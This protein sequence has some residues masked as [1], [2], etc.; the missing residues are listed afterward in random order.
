MMPLTAA[1]AEKIEQNLEDMNEDDGYSDLLNADLDAT[2][3]SLNTLFSEFSRIMS[4]DRSGE[5]LAD[6]IH[7]D[8]AD[9]ESLRALLSRIQNDNKILVCKQVEILGISHVNWE[10][11]TFLISEKAS[12][13]ELF[14]LIGGV[15]ESLLMLCLGCEEENELI[16][17][18]RIAVQRPESNET[19]IYTIQPEDLNLGLT[20]DEIDIIRKHSRFASHYLSVGAMCGMPRNEKH[21]R[22]LRCKSQ[23]ITLLTS[24]GEC[25]FCRD[26]PYPEVIY[27]AVDGQMHYTPSLYFNADTIQ[28]ESGERLSKKACICC[29]RHVTELRNGLYCNLCATAMA[30]QGS[31]LR[32]GTENYKKYSSILPLHIRIAAVKKTKLC[33]EDAE[34]ILFVIDSEK[35][36][37]HKTWL[38]NVGHLPSPHKL[39]N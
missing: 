3:G 36:A 2:T 17:G 8:K 13:R 30:P 5:I 9:K 39:N 34:L 24:N 31:D 6:C 15:D 26:C 25:A 22:R 12:G 7:F 11:Q 28:L 20:Q 19:K 29:G 10:K 37:F 1:D 21:C 4:E 33:F 18:N 16:V 14:H 38:N 27:K 35:Y 23:L 32:I